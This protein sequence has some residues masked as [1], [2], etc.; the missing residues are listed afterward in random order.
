MNR[1][2][3]ASPVLLRVF[4]DPD[5]GRHVEGR[6]PVEHVAANLC[7]G[8]LIGQSPGVKPPVDNGLVAIHCGF[9]QAPAIVA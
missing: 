1:S 6:H 8:V 7:L 3:V 9:D 2:L 4:A 5:G